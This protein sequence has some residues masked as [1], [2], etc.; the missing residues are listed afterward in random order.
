MWV[1]T[2]ARVLVITWSGHRRTENLCSRL[3][4]TYMTIETR[5]GGLIRYLRLTPRTVAAIARARPEVLVVQNPS[6]I[7]ATLCVLLRPLL[8]YLLVVDAHNEAVRPFNLAS[9]PLRWISRQCLRHA[10]LTIVTNDALARVV[11]AVGGKPFVLPDPLPVPPPTPATVGNDPGFKVVVISTFSADEPLEEI[12]CAASR[13]QGTAQFSV[14]GD[15]RRLPRRLRQQ[16]PPNVAFTGFLRELDYW[17]LLKSCDV[18]VDLTLMPDCLVCGAY[19]A[20]AVRKPIIMTDSSSA[21]AWFGDAAIYVRNHADSIEQALRD[22]KNRREYW[23]TQAAHAVPRIERAWD[24]R[25]AALPSYLA[26]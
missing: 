6:L 2:D 19:E 22:V 9:A 17:A 24:E 18:V 15:L 20:I 13:L 7:L 12:V 23:R 4:W 8:R 25:R 26:R 21:R 1:L 11:D 3:G 16:A 14:T 10:D 5:S